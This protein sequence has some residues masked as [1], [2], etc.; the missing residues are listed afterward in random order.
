MTYKKALAVFLCA[1]RPFSDYWE[2]Q[3]AWSCYVD[4]LHRDGMITDR[5]A[6]T[7]DNPCTPETFKRFNKKFEGA[8]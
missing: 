7:W 8:V 1:N 4:G 6:R 5:Q 2:M 3:L